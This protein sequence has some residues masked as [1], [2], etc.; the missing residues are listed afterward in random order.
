L[1]LLDPPAVHAVAAH[2][3]TLLTTEGG[4]Q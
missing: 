1:N 2:L 3:R 4:Y